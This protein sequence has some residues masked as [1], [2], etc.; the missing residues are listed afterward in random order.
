METVWREERSSGNDFGLFHVYIP[1][2]ISKVIS[3]K[4]SFLIGSFSINKSFSRSYDFECYLSIYGAHRRIHSENLK[5]A[6]PSSGDS[7]PNLRFPS[8][9]FLSPP[10]ILPENTSESSFPSV[11]G[12][13]GETLDEHGGLMDC[14]SVA[15]Q[16]QSPIWVHF[17]GDGILEKLMFQGHL[18]PLSNVIVLEYEPSHLLRCLMNSAQTFIGIPP[19]LADSFNYLVS[20]IPKEDKL[21][22]REFLR[23]IPCQKELMKSGWCIASNDTPPNDVGS[24]DRNYGETWVGSINENIISKSVGITQ[25]LFKWSQLFEVKPWKA[26]I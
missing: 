8:P 20:K 22:D 26:L 4:T 3:W 2:E 11:I 18:V 15:T 7:M 21:K 9:S 1:K 24:S 23:L 17:N 6:D 13:F 12:Y 16:T 25:L 10:K 14:G 5:N 19:V